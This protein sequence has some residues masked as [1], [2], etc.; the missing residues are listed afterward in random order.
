[1]PNSSVDIVV[2][3]P[4]YLIAYKTGWRKGRHQCIIKSFETG[5]LVLDGFMG[6][7]TTALAAIRNDR[8]FIG[9]ELDDYYFDVACNRLATK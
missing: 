5:G 8:H 7:G 6:S 9:W 3:D 2:T 1:M 4:P